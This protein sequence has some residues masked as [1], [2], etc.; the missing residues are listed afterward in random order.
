M[1]IINL[2]LQLLSSQDMCYNNC[3]RKGP[4]RMLCRL[5]KAFDSVWRAGLWQVM[6]HLRYDEK[7]IRLLEALYKD[8][9]SAVRVDGSWGTDQLVQTLSVLQGYIL[10]PLLFNI[11]LEVVMASATT[12]VEFRALLSGHRIS[13]C[14]LHADD[15]GCTTLK[16]R[17]ILC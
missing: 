14:G 1:G 7:I 6:R 11:L 16:I 5:P 17:Y 13:N 10:S 3:D 9:M 8:T 15:T 12:D 4:L 2:E